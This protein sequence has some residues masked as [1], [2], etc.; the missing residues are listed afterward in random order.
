P[1]GK[2]LAP[3]QFERQW[4]GGKPTDKDLA[5]MAAEYRHRYPTKPVI[6]DFNQASWAFLCAGGSLP[7]LPATTDS[8]LLA[9]IPRLQPWADACGNNRWVL[10]EPGRNYL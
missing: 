5:L 4:R 3:R 1:G 10:R 6:C 9:A 7:N 2:N 8:R